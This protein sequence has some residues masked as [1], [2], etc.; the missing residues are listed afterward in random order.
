MTLKQFVKPAG[1]IA[2]FAAIV[3]AGMLSSSPRTRAIADD[4]ESNESKIQ[5]G[6]EIAPV[7]LN[8]AGKNREL[9]GLGSYIVNAQGDCNGCHSAGPATEFAPGGNPY[10][11]QPEK[12]NRA[13]YL[14]GGRDFGPFPGPGPCWCSAAETASP[15]ARF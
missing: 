6:F 5:R 15:F 1:A 9:V 14:G 13:T 2:I 3:L 4:N 10:F 7:P 11:G 12:I 8:L